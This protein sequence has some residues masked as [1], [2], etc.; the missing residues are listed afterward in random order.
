[1][2]S[3]R[4]ILQKKIKACIVYNSLFFLKLK[5]AAERVECALAK[6]TA[7]VQACNASF[8]TKGRGE[9]SRIINMLAV[10]KSCYYV[11]YV[12]YVKATSL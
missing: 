11:A 5:F 9:T 12:F 8:A 7:N 6:V 3:L 4:Q 1:M 10:Y 2:E